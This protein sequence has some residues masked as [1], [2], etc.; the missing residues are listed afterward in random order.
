MKISE[1]HSGI[2]NVNFGRPLPDK[3]LNAAAEKLGIKIYVYDVKSL[4]L[5]NGIPFRSIR[6]TAKSLIISSPSIVKYIDSGKQFKGYY[7]YSKIQ[8]RLNNHIS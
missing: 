3:V 2:N 8:L 1:S 5:L 7:F 4:T 6:L